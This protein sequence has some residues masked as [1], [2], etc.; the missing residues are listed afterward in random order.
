MTAFKHT[1][2]NHRG[3]AAIADW[4]MMLY[5][6]HIDRNRVWMF[7]W[8]HCFVNDLPLPATPKEGKTLRDWRAA[9]NRIETMKNLIA[10]H[11]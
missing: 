5:G 1:F 3:L 6:K 2:K 7:A 11:S 4:H 8:A 10:K 9:Q